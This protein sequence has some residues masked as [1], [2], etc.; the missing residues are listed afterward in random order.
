MQYIDTTIRGK[1]NKPTYISGVNAEIKTNQAELKPAL[2]QATT[3]GAVMDLCF[4]W[5]YN[6]NL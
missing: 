1:H 4:L 2:S 5:A 6:I 3:G